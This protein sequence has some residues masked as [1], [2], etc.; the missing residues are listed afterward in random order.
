MERQVKEHEI[1]GEHK[2]IREI[3]KTYV[4]IG[5]I[6]RLWDTHRAPQ[7]VPGVLDGDTYVKTKTSALPT[8]VKALATHFWTQDV[9][10]LFE[11]LLKEQAEEQILQ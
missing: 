6:E 2:F 10:D 4:T 1:K 8:D 11:A 9:H 5:G 7:H 3:T